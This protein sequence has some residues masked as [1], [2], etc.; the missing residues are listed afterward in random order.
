L[1]AF[2]N[3]RK[4]RAHK[5]RRN[6]TSKDETWSGQTPA[7]C[8]SLSWASDFGYEGAF[9][10]LLRTEKCDLNAKDAYGRTPLFD[11]IGRKWESAVVTLLSDENFKVDVQDNLG[12]TPSMFAI[13]KNDNRMIELLLRTEKGGIELKENNGLTATEFVERIGRRKLAQLIR[14]HSRLQ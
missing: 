13:E 8:L 1:D 3:R 10:L 11:A 7:F 2:D 6:A 9:D 12:K 4:I 5:Y 14:T